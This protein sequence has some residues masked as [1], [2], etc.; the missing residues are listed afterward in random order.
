M[1]PWP[2]LGCDPAGF[3]C[4]NSEYSKKPISIMNQVTFLVDGFNL[5]HSVR[6]AGKVLNTSTKWLDIKTLCSSYLHIIG[7]IVGDKTKLKNI[8]YFSALAKHIEA[9]D[10]DVTAR[11]KSFLKCLRDTGVFV[12]LSRFK[13]KTIKCPFCGKLFVKYEEKE[14]DVAI[15]IKLLDILLSDECNTTVLLTGDTDIAPAVKTANRLFPKKRILFAFPYL[16]KN[17]EL[18]K[19]APGSFGINKKQYAKY[20]FP[21]PYEL[22]DGILINKPLTW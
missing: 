18:L 2:P 17:R 14:T 12:E 19:L 7:G 10:P 6:E 15:A 20:Q 1:A 8:Y 22:S 3:F 5:Y 16:R 21:D 9:K 4:L 13:P 11:H